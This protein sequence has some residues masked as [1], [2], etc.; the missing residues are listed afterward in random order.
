[1]HGASRHPIVRNV[2][3]ALVFFAVT[4]TGLHARVGGLQLS[5]ERVVGL[6]MLP[7][8]VFAAL[9]TKAFNA[10]R[11]ALSLWFLWCLVELLSALLSSG[12]V[13]HL[14]YLLIALVPTAIFAFLTD[15]RL[16]T[17]FVARCVRWLL[18]MHG[19]GTV[20][21]VALQQ[22]INMDFGFLRLV[23]EDGRLML[24]SVEPNIFGSYIAFLILLSLPRIRW[25]SADVIM[26]GLA[27]AGLLLA[28][29]RGPLLSFAIGVCSYFILTSF[30]SKK[31]VG[32]RIIQL[33]WAVMI[34]LIAF[35][36]FS[37]QVG[38][39][40]ATNLQRQSTI[41][42]RSY[43]LD[44]A[45]HRFYGAPILGRGPGDFSLQDPSALRKFGGEA[46]GSNMF[47]WQMFANIM[48]DS[49]IVGLM[50]YVSFL[51]ALFKIGFD[52]IKRG[53]AD[54]CGYM[55]AF[56]SILIASQSSTVHL[57]AIFGLGCGLLACAPYVLRRTSRPTPR[58]HG[59][60]GRIAAP[61]RHAPSGRI[62]F[63]GASHR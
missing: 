29:S 12:F 30:A 49:G 55:A 20:I 53:S 54:H 1:M 41:Y 10:A 27:F 11:P 44:Q 43:F 19:I 13:Q 21:V 9:R 33:L 45:M 25:R 8:L 52:W 3:V 14:T 22:K 39:A 26:L 34:I 31:N 4:T 2:V 16:D 40:Y 15:K 18:W 6:A 35:M 47:I 57:N 50:I 58:V 23:G 62:G 7:L 32:N 5:P 24:L 17:D 38:D 42:V 48:H 28:R 60:S 37:N 36:I 59:S 56:L 51:V 61:L 46:V 63:A